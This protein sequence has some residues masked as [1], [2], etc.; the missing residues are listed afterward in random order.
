MHFQHALLNLTATK[1]RT[2][3]AL[4]GIL[5]GTASVVAMITCGELATQAALAQFKNLGTDMLAASVFKQEDEQT[6]VDPITLNKVMALPKIIP[7]IT[8]VAPYSLRFS[9]VSYQDQPINAGIIGA[10][11]ILAKAINITIQQGRF[12]SDLDKDQNFCVIGANIFNNL[13]IPAKKIIGQ[14]LKI[15]SNFFTIIG[16]A[17]PWPENSFFNQDVNSAIIVPFAT[18]KQLNNDATIDNLVF[19]LQL[20]ANVGDV[21]NKLTAFFVG[22]D[23]NKKIFFRSAKELVQ[24]MAAQHKIFTLLLGLIGSIS[25]VV[26]G[27]GVMNIMLV[28][29]LERKREIGIRL[30]IGAKHSDIQ[31]MF[32]SE[33]ILLAMIGGLLGT[34]LG[35]IISFIV[36]KI[37]NWEF[38]LLIFPIMIGFTISALVGII[39][40]FF[41]AHQAAKLDPIQTL[42]TD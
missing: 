26:G 33:A 30:A 12:I 10:T 37:A 36:A 25:L 42:R 20:N 40:G 34:L 35:V 28:S 23:S 4:L 17:N 21:K 19:H 9:T 1:M 3:L 27:I 6:D 11:Q 7:A 38:Q 41:P 32:L 15:G 2:L 5:I 39:S 24:S 31:W 13:R 29:V 22:T 14:Q 18:I 8:L 16:V